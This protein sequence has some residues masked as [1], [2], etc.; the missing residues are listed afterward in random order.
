MALI[1]TLLVLGVVAGGA[2]WYFKLGPG[3]KRQEAV[4]AEVPSRPAPLPATNPPSLKETIITADAPKIEKSIDDLKPGT[5]TLE[6]AK[7]GNLMYAVGTIRNDSPHQRFG[8]KVEIEFTD[9]KG[10]PAGKTRDYTQVIEPGREWRFRALVLDA[11]AAQ[12]KVV[13]IQEDN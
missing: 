5:V 6:K 2:L 12:G 8:V 9:A 11:K 4:A 7:S 3:S 1:V 13:G 10:R